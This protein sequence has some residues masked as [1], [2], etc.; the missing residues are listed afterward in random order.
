MKIGSAAR[1]LDTTPRTLRFYEELGLLRVRKT[2][3]GTRDYTEDDL[4]RLEAILTLTRLGIP[5]E[6]VRRLA[7]VRTEGRT[8]DEANQQVEPCLAD[9]H[10]TIAGQRQQLERLEAEIESAE[11][12]VRGCRGCPN[13]PTERGCPECPVARHRSEFTL[14]SLLWEQPG[15][16]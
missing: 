3:G 2:P 15:D 4:A 10:A 16:A 14:L 11:A 1:R 12:L 9:L 8:G 6:Q 5:V 13:P 7:T